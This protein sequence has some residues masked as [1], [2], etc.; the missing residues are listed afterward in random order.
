[1]A[2]WVCLFDDTPEMLA[3]RAERR[4]SHHAF[5]AENAGRILRAGALCP[6]G[7]GPP[8]GGLWVLNVASR[9]E[10]VGLIE[11]DPYFLPQLR[12]YRLFEWKWALDYPADL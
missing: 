2:R 10:A 1:M 11:R 4:T 6:D 8:T 12:S 3:V 9:E 7:D 5:L